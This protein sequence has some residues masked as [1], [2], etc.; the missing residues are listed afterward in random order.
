M[1][2]ACDSAAAVEAGSAITDEA[3]SGVV[4]SPNP[5]SPLV[6]TT[7]GTA[8]MEAICS[9]VSEPPAPDTDVLVDIGDPGRVGTSVTSVTADEEMVEL[10]NIAIVESVLYFF[11]S[12]AKSS[13]G[14]ATGTGFGGDA[15][16]VGRSNAFDMISSGGCARGEMIIPGAFDGSPGRRDQ[17]AIEVYAEREVA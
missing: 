3:A 4:V 5:V 13:D 15:G 12:C 14:S 8:G 10:A 9:F 7:A 17:I 1:S 2:V 11:S 16:G 6:A